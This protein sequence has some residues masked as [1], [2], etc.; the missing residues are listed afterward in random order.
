MDDMTVI[1]EW[2]ELNRLCTSIGWTCGSMG[3]GYLELRAPCPDRAA[4]DLSRIIGHK[5]KSVTSALGFIHG[6]MAGLKEVR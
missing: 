4:G 3:N 6:Y 2:K 1:R 5:T